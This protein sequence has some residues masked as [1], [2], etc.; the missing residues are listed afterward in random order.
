MKKLIL[1]FLVLTTFMAC[2]KKI[3]PECEAPSLEDSQKLEPGIEEEPG[4]PRPNR[5]GEAYI[6][7]FYLE[8]CPSCDDYVQ[9][10][11]IEAMLKNAA[12]NGYFPWEKIHLISTNV[13]QNE[14]LKQ[15]QSYIEDGDFPDVS[16]S[17]PVIF[18]NQELVVGYDEIEK[19][20]V[21]L[22][23]F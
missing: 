11:R 23:E 22:T 15:L 6:A 9:A 5:S 12:K 20:V 8:T 21:G 1:L 14:H 7:F 16:K 3:E 10:K 17:L 18:V 19:L 13:L 2:Q 4:D